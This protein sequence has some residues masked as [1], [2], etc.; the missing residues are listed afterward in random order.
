VRLSPKSDSHQRVQAA[1]PPNGGLHTS[2][3]SRLHG[4][5][6][7]PDSIKILT[8]DGGGVRGII[9]AVVLGEIERRTGQHPSEL[10]DV[11]AGT[12][13]GSLLAMSMAVPGKDGLPRYQATASADAYEE[14]A[15]KIFPRER[16][17]QIR[18]LVHEKYS[19]TGLERALQEFLGEVRLSEALVHTL[20]PTYD[21]MSQ[22]IHV[23]D[24]VQSAAHVDDDILMR[25]VV[26]GATAAPTYFD[27]FV[28]GPPISAHK[29]VLIDGGLYA[30]NPSVLALTQVASR[31][32]GSD[33][34][35]VSL[36]TG[37]IPAQPVD[38]E[39]QDWGL[40]RWVKPLLHIVASGTNRLI[41]LELEHFLG[42]ERYFRFQAQLP[43]ECELDDATPKTFQGLR[44]VGEDLVRNSSD[45]LD[46]VCALL[47][48]PR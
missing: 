48:R 34:L 46:K 43:E 18:G 21:L 44:N 14:F 24:S 27:P 22:D 36:G 26:R 15:P 16:W 8:I 11:I 37:R 32:T 38:E 6:P 19:A 5:Q 3:L 7:A 10:F 33:V 17:L 41:D 30:N 31:H 2:V 35:V 20:V 13:T 39:G 40:A 4:E 25:H 29:S 23:F 1:T 42:T 47:T 45:D 12:S 9:P 28:V